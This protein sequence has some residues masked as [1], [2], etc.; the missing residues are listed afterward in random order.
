MVL[1]GV[2]VGV[3]LIRYGLRPKNQILYCRERDGRGLEL[4]IDAEDALSM[5]TKTK[6]QLR[7]YKYGRAYDF[8]KRGRAYT[9]FFGKEGTAYTWRLQGFTEKDKVD[10]QFPTLEQAVKSQWGEEFYATVPDKMQELLRGKSL[11]VTVNLEAGIVPKGYE[12]ISEQTIKK[13]ANEDM[14]SLLSNALKGV[15]KTPVMQWMFILGSGF[16]AG[17][18]VHTL[19]M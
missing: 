10:L 17:W 9:R 2:L 13:K 12:P 14:A 18:I 15:V 11:L 19:F 4:N 5:T 1:I 6:P 16:G 3:I 8:Q 7:F